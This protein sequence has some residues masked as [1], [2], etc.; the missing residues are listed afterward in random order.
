MT[1][2]EAMRYLVVLAPLVGCSCAVADGGLVLTEVM[3]ESAHPSG[4]ANGDWWEL[5][6]TGQVAVDLA[7][8]SWSDSDNLP[9]ETRFPNFT[10]GPGQSILVVNENAGNLAGFKRAWGLAFSDASVLSKDR[11]AGEGFSRLNAT[12]DDVY[13]YNAADDVVAH[14]RFGSAGAG[15]R[16]FAWDTTGTFLGLSVLGQRGAYRATSNG[17]GGAGVDVASPGIAFFVGDLDGDGDV[18]FDDIGAFVVGINDPAAYEQIYGM[19]PSEHGDTDRDG[20]FDFDD[21]PGFVTLLGGAAGS[22]AISVQDVQD[23]PEP[24]IMGLVSW[25]LGGL[26]A[27]GHACRGR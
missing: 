14:V 10:I 17:A 18:D 12:A 19:P 23:V 1:Q 6:N 25:A 2:H 21:I 26:L 15:G 20:D 9:G 7:G 16:S 24:S 13:V 8:F 22:R 4:T 3:S 5:T 27:I 11:F